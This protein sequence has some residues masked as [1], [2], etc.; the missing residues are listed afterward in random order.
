MLHEQ[1][2][3]YSFN[4]PAAGNCI[5]PYFKAAK[6][7]PSKA[8]MDKTVLFGL[9]DGTAINVVFGAEKAALVW[10]INP[11]DRLRASGISLLQPLDFFNKGVNDLIITRDDSSIEF[12]SL[13]SERVY[14]LQFKNELNEGI[15]SVDFGQISVPGV[16]E[17]VIS[18]YSGK[19]IG[20]LDAEDVMK[21]EGKTGERQ[22][23]RENE[24]KI[25]LLHQEI[26][27]LVQTINQL[28]AES[29]AENSQNQNVPTVANTFKV[30]Y[31]IS[32]NSGDSSY[33]IHIE[34]QFPMEIVAL[35]SR[36]RME[37]VEQASGN[38]I[39]SLSP[40]DPEHKWAFSAT[41]RFVENKI[42]KFEI[43]IKT[44]EGQYGD[45][46]AYVIPYAS[47][48][49]AQVL[50]IPVKPLSLHERY[51]GVSFCFQYTSS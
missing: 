46:T 33:S 30:N 39:L 13:N 6:L 3:Q 11:Q 22:D 18:T 5:Q 7:P 19:L 35:E 49:T 41:Y 47:P 15:T 48:K 45:I 20:F 10:S 27:K 51:G 16:N 12:Y 14:E 8:E 44:V 37:L 31:K 21:M 9:N 29:Q 42:S 26:D 1:N 24:K 25:K 34:S 40:G 2:V 43:K 17:F 4:V 32:K 28:K 50:K 36:V 38:A 23:A